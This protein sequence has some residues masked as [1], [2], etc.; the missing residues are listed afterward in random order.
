MKYKRFITGIKRK[1]LKSLDVARVLGIS[2]KELNDKLRGKKPLYIHE[3][4]RIFECLGI[5]SGEE[6]IKFF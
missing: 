2:E 4:E 1:K 5:E 6:K 3:A